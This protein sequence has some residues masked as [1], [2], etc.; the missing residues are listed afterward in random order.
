MLTACL[1]VLVSCSDDGP[2]AAPSTSRATTTTAS[3]PAPYTDRGDYEVGTYTV[4]LADGRRVVVWYPAAAAAADQPTES[5]DIASLL[6]PDL[7][8]KIPLTCELPTRWRRTRGRPGERPL[9][10]ALQPRRRFPE[11]SVDLDPRQLGSSSR[12][13]T[14]SSARCAAS[15][16]GG[17]GRGAPR[18]HRRAR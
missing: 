14:T 18:G 10:R 16:H 6:R 13:P 8:Q 3:S 15:W 9:R 17:P 11:Q 7:Q 4:A 12:L 5:F 1:L 2:E